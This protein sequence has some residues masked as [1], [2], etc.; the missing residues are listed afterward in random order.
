MSVMHAEIERITRVI[1]KVN[2]A[3][4]CSYYAKERAAFDGDDEAFVRAGIEE[5]AYELLNDPT[6]EIVG[7]GITIEGDYDDTDV[8]IL[9][10][11]PA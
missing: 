7:D 3:E 4:H 11:R 5:M 6:E 10:T 9:G 2:V 1:V 8:T